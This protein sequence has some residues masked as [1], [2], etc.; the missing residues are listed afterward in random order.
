MGHNEQSAHVGREVRPGFLGGRILGAVL[1]NVK[2]EKVQ[3]D[4]LGK[5]R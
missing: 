2:A 5:S 1:T 3:A 4:Y